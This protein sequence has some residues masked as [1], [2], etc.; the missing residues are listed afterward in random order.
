MVEAHAM[1]V[2]EMGSLLSSH[3]A[4]DNTRIARR[5]NLEGLRQSQS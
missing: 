5:F 1:A 4:K 3:I 2:N